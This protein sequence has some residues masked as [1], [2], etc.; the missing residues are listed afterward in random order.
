MDNKMPT[1]NELTS[2]L[3]AALSDMKA[4]KDVLEK[5]QTAV[6]VASHAFTDAQNKATA[7][8][9]KLLAAM[10]SELP[11]ASPHVKQSV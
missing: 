10:E 7:A 4:K 2:A 6:A 1:L 9:Q 11:D 8:K 3:D 5:A